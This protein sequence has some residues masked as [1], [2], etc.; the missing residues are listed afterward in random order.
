MQEVLLFDSS[1]NP[2]VWLELMRPGQY[3]VFLSDAETRAGMTP[4]GRYSGSEVADSCL[5]FDSFEEAEEYCRTSVHDVARLRCEIFDDRGKAIPP[6]AVFVSPEFAGT[7]HS[8]IKARRLTWAGI[9]LIAVSVPLFW[10]DWRADWRLILPT[11]VGSQ[12]ILVGL[13]FI[14]L[15]SATKE[16]A[17]RS[18]GRGEAAHKR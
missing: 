18:R 16:A 15:G 14:Q 7:L 12:F 17:R 5:I 10:L 6:A 4:D 9:I 11:V 2:A 3:A 13:R 1:R 8:D